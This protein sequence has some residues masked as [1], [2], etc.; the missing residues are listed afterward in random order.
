MQLGVTITLLIGLLAAVGACSIGGALWAYRRVLIDHTTGAALLASLAFGGVIFAGGWVFFAPA[1]LGG[2]LRRRHR[3][4]GR[5]MR[6]GR[7]VLGLL[8][9]AG[10]A[11]MV[12]GV[13]E[14][15]QD[16]TEARRTAALRTHGVT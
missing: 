12:I 15:L 7:F 10:I 14:V 5:R 16:R 4:G 8:S 1:W 3:P 11:V 9:L 2:W 6:T 13:G